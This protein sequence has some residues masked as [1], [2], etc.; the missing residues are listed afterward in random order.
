MPKAVAP[1]GSYKAIVA[2]S[3]GFRPAKEEKYKV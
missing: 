2:V 3:K 1:K